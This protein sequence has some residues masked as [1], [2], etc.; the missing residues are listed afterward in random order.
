MNYFIVNQKDRMIWQDIPEPE[1][2]LNEKRAYEA[3]L[4]FPYSTELNWRDWQR[5]EEGKDFEIRWTNGL[6]SWFGDKVSNQDWLIALP[7]K[8][9]E[10]KTG[11]VMTVY[12]PCDENDEMAVGSFTSLDGQS[13][14]YVREMKLKL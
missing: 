8:D 14:C 13:L 10:E 1:Q 12:V 9:K 2:G 6:A 4:R 11:D 5:V 3:R 7:S